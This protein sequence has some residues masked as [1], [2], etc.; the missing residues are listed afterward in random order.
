MGNFKTD[1]TLFSLIKDSHDYLIVDKC[2]G[3]LS[4]PGTAQEKKSP[5]FHQ[6]TISKI[7]FGQSTGQT[8]EWING[9]L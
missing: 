5:D 9:L 6:K 1:D 2:G 8:S 4:Q 7:S 3:V